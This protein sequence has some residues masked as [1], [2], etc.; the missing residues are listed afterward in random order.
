MEVVHIAYKASGRITV[1]SHGQY[2]N[3]DTHIDVY[4]SEVMCY[5]LVLTA[6]QVVRKYS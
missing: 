6:R 5:M 1:R 3:H 2:A 4:A